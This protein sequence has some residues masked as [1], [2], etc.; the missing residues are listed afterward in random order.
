MSALRRASV[1]AVICLT[2]PSLARA[3]RIQAP[4]AGFAVEVGRD[5]AERMG[6]FQQRLRSAGVQGYVNLFKWNAPSPDGQTGATI[7]GLVNQQNWRGWLSDV[8]PHTIGFMNNGA[9]NSPGG[10][11]Y[12]RIGKHFWPY[13][14]IHHGVAN[15]GTLPNQPWT[16]QYGK[17]VEATF[18]ASA[19]EIDAA[20]AFCAAR[21][22]RQVNNARG[23]P[24]IPRWVN[25]GP[26]NLKTEG[27]AGASSSMLNPEWR[28]AFRQSVDSIRA[29]G[30][31]NNIRV[32][33]DVTVATA[34][35]LDGFC[36][37]IGA[38]QYTTPK[39]LTVKN[40][41]KPTLGM[42]TLF[43][44]QRVTGR[45]T[46]GGAQLSPINDPLNQIIWG[47]N[48]GGYTWRSM[49]NPAIIPDT[50]PGQRAGTSFV[51][52][53]LPLEAIGE[54]LRGAGR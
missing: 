4:G 50:A 16:D 35:A 49:G 6:R 25:P 7:V 22:Y 2:V 10:T 5:Q 28:Q 31:R 51:S 23:E 42:I 11:G 48:S 15:Y 21:A 43:N 40:Y 54:Q 53:R 29:Y 46:W 33:A 32:L 20:T 9:P 19:Q 18:E 39:H 14:T 36:E 34:D 52:H 47:S 44:A 38:Q 3:E 8:A 24:I 1:L 17:Y 12:L 30:R 26:S 13:G 41:A 45:D 27:C 37:R